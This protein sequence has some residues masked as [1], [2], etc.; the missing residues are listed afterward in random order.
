MVSMASGLVPGR[1]ATRA[2]PVDNLRLE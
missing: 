2:E 1:Q